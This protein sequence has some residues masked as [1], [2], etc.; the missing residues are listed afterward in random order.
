VGAA[1]QVGA[2]DAVW[3]PWVVLDACARAS[4]TAR[5]HAFQHDRAQALGSGMHRGGESGGARPDDDDVVELVLG[6][7]AQPSAAC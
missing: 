2:A 5:R 1:G 3:E 7:R 6:L 4:L